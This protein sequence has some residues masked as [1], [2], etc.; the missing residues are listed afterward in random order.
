MKF[1]TVFKTVVGVS[2]A[3]LTTMATLQTIKEYKNKT[4]VFAEQPEAVETTELIDTDASPKM[5]VEVKVENPTL[6]SKKN[7]RDAG[8]LVAGGVIAGFIIGVKLMGKRANV[9]IES[10]RNESYDRGF[11]F[12]YHEGTT[13]M[14][15]K[16]LNQNFD[17]EKTQFAL[18]TPSPGFT[19]DN[20]VT[21]D[22]L[23]YS[24]DENGLFDSI[25]EFMQTTFGYK[26]VNVYEEDYN[27]AF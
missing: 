24:K 5:D 27:V 16:A 22:I 18:G 23:V 14:I 11:N 6:F 9:A 7:L 20:N 15:F 12:G 13:S 3:A 4:G 8:I 19:N 25:K 1:E 21:P 26:D 2:M 17:G 10:A